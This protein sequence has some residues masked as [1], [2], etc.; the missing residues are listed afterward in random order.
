M[1]KG[2]CNLSAPRPPS[3]MC[4]MIWSTLPVPVNP[5]MFVPDRVCVHVWLGIC[6]KQ[7]VMTCFLI[8]RI[9]WC[10]PS[11]SV[12]ALLV[13]LIWLPGNKTCLSWITPKKYP[14]CFASLPEIKNVRTNT[15]PFNGHV[16]LLKS[17]WY[18]QKR[19]QRDLTKYSLL[20]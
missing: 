20:M 3:Y 4:I 11:G 16:L 2:I 17:S 15:I 18:R 1:K 14:I 12:K 19:M 7:M 9:L 6:K 13:S 10:V 8:R 5:R